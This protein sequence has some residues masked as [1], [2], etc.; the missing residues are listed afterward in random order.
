MKILIVGPAWVGDMVIAHGLVRALRAQEPNVDIHVLAP[1]ATEPLTRRM[2]GVAGSTVLPV[3]HG[4]FGWRTRR[5]VG[6]SLADAAYDQAIV[7]PNSFKSALVPFFASIPRRTGW[8]GEWRY[9]VLNDIRVLDAKNYPRLIDRFVALG[10]D[11]GPPRE[12]ARS[13]DDVAGVEPQ[14]TADAAR[15]QVLVTELGLPADG[16]V[17][18]M[19]P[20]AEYGPAK[21][22]PPQHYAAVA[23]DHIRR[24]GIVWLFG[25]RGD[26]P[27]CA[28]IT[29]ALAPA[30]RAHVF[31]LAGRTR[32]LD[33]IDLLSLAAR[34]VTNDSGLMHV[35][36]A[37]GRP[38]VAI[39]GSSSPDFTP[40]LAATARVVRDQ[41]PC[42]PCFE[43]TCPL[44]HTHCLNRLMPQRVLAE[45]SR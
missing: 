37:L 35:A 42:S 43:R 18:A 15:A 21:R 30:D 17:L 36:C 1:A 4:E 3:S 25:A 38:V 26:A 12:T 23:A 14:L 7:L 31:D 19:C 34:V 40:P 9:A 39:Y 11:D 33:A 13:R 29:A 41:L 20:G 10:R 44:G 8:R 5:Q 16:D 32:L 2:P 28:A 45:L 24:G 27:S 22:W 6:R